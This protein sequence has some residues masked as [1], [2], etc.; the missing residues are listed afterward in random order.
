MIFAAFFAA[1]FLML[2]RIVIRDVEET[3]ATLGRITEGNL[4]E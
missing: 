1:I 4:E 2:K 3:H